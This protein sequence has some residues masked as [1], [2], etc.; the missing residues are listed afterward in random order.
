MGAAD[1]NDRVTHSHEPYF[2]PWA[3]HQLTKASPEKIKTWI[4]LLLEIHKAEVKITNHDKATAFSLA[5]AS[6]TEQHLTS[7]KTGKDITDIKNFVE[8]LIFSNTGKNISMNTNVTITTFRKSLRSLSRYLKWE[9]TLWKCIK[10]Q[11]NINPYYNDD[12]I[13]KRYINDRT[14]DD[15]QDFMKSLSSDMIRAEYDAHFS[16]HFNDIN[17]EVAE[18]N[19]EDTIL[20]TFLIN[21]ISGTLDFPEEISDIEKSDIFPLPKKYILERIEFPY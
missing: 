10:N 9:M 11:V 19:W 3:W 7:P 14:F 12:L 16:E 2:S 1:S 5:L 4:S 18:K 8:Y 21:F 17:T 15:I 20:S 13:V 6:V